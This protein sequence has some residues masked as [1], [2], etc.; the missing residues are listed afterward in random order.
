MKIDIKALPQ[1]FDD[2]PAGTFFKVM[3]SEPFFGLS[4]IDSQGKKAAILFVKV[5]QQTSVPWLAERG[6]PH[7]VLATFPDAVIHAEAS[8]IS[9]PTNGI[10]Y[11][12]ILSTSKGFYIRAGAGIGY[13]MIFNLD[14]GQPE[15]I[16][17]S[18]KPMLVYERWSI[19]HRVGNEIE[20]IFD[21]P[22][23]AKN[24]REPT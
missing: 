15:T 22:L 18:D 16:S 2:I 8:A 24:Q 4:V 19:G 1:N 9:E 7:D 14:T 20:P 23:R 5:P 10:P 11:G 17:D 12:A 3:R 21:Y 6:L 13:S